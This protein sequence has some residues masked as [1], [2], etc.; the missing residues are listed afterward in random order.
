M[1]ETEAAKTATGGPIRRLARFMGPLVPR[2]YARIGL[3]AVLGGINLAITVYLPLLN[4]GLIDSL[5]FGNRAVFARMIMVLL[6]CVAVQITLATAYRYASA[7]LGEAVHSGLRRKLVRAVLAKPLSFFRTFQ[8]GDLISRTAT[9]T[10]ALKTF[11]SSVVLQLAF[12]LATMAAVGLILFRMDV[13]LALVTVA[14]GPLSI[15][16]GGLF[17]GPIQKSNHAARTLLGDVMA[18]MQGWLGRALALKASLLET[19]IG[20]A[21]ARKDESLRKA[22]VRVEMIE[23]AA[24]GLAQ[25]VLA[26]PSICVFVLGGGM[27]MRGHLTIGSLVAFISYAAYFNAP[28]QRVI[29]LLVVTVPSMAAPLER[30]EAVTEAP[31]DRPGAVPAIGRAIGLSVEDLQFDLGDQASRVKVPR[32]TAR[33]GEVVGV[34]GANGCGKTTLLTTLLSLRPTSSG[35]VSLETEGTTVP[36][37]RG[38]CSFLPQ[39]SVVLDGTLRDNIT[40]FEATPDRER[41]ERITRAL[42]MSWIDGLPGGLDAVIDAGSLAY[43]SGGQLQ[44]IGLARAAYSTHAVMILDEPGT[45]LDADALDRAARLIRGERDR[46]TVVISHREEVLNVCDRIYEFRSSTGE[47]EAAYDVVER[48][49]TNA[50]SPARETGVI[51]SGA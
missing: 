27:V 23:A 40:L 11:Y 26:V 29:Q 38:L 8:A 34:V 22:S 39:D 31:E 35:Q 19:V 33:R 6:A 36:L 46:I 12:D 4:K 3:I 51:S 41:L 10:Q 32:L 5:Q 9:D 42:G 45:S 7:W 24:T 17:Q 2:L 30:L 1:S 13:K 44:Q 50:R 48:L 21:F 20:G 16:L 37:H 28:L 47:S 25:A 18:H 14:S 49:R 15:V 43:L